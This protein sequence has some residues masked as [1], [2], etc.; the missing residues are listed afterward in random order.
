M[1]VMHQLN[2]TFK[3]I[4]FETGAFSSPK[5][6]K[7]QE[8]GLKAPTA[9]ALALRLFSGVILTLCSVLNNTFEVPVTEG[10]ESDQDRACHCQGRRS[11]R[12][13]SH[14]QLELS[15]YTGLTM[16][17]YRKK[18]NQNLAQTHAQLKFL[19]AT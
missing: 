18:L 4:L 19:G 12:A 10:S 5:T 13:L 6:P 16:E 17:E 3:D 1:A 11:S 8:T 2:R 7:S 15:V 14:A 9:G